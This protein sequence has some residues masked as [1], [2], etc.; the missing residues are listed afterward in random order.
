MLIKKVTQQIVRMSAVV[1]FSILAMVA[2]QIIWKIFPITQ[3]P[4]WLNVTV[5]IFICL[6]VVNLI[7]GKKLFYDFVEFLNEISE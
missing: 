4:N 1:V 6:F 7:F 2:S 3:E 5:Y